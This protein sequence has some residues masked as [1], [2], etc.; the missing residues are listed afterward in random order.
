[1]DLPT[2]L[3]RMLEVSCSKDTVKN[4]NIYQEKEGSYVFKIRFSPV[5]DRHVE[6]SPIPI[7]ESACNL[8]NCAYKRKSVKQ[9]SRDSDRH[10]AWQERR[11][12]RSQTAAKQSKEQA[13]GF[14][15]VR[16]PSIEEE[17]HSSFQSDITYSPD[18]TPIK[19]DETKRE[20]ENVSISDDVIHLRVCEKD[21]DPGKCE[22]DNQFEAPGNCNPLC[23]FMEGGTGKQ[24]AYVCQKCGAGVCVCEICIQ[25]GAH[26]C[27]RKYLKLIKSASDILLRS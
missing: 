8:N 2:P 10:I 24:V 6:S 14:S 16:P 5:L 26:Y 25:N 11:I 9:V 19:M 15:S 22:F 3:L 17:R 4:W 23:M 1:M 12:T 18:F 7:P 27:H 20:M 21:C 13:C